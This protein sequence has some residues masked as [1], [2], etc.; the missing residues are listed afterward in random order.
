MALQQL[1]QHEYGMTDDDV[2][3]IT[4]LLLADAASVPKAQR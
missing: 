4:R 2:T 1:H 3:A